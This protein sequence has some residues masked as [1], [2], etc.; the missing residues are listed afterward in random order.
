MIG[1]SA[2]GHDGSRVG[3]DQDDVKALF[4][5]GPAGLGAGVIEFGRLA[6]DDRAGADH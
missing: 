2:V 6:D 1:H 5:Q 3:V 4:L